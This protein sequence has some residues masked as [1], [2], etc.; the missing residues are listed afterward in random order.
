[1][2]FIILGG[3]S[4]P[5]IIFLII[6]A[7]ISRFQNWKSSMGIVL[8]SGVAFNLFVIIVFIC[9]LLTP[10]VDKLFPDNNLASFDD[11]FSGC[12]VMLVLAVLGGFLLK[13]RSELK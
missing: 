13:S 11:Y 10:E 5:A 2:K 8:L 7:A 9:I 3:F 6:G 4:L 1:M 12:S